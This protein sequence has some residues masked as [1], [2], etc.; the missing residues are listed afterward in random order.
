M[1]DNAKSAVHVLRSIEEPEKVL[2]AC[3]LWKCWHRR[4]K[5]NAGEKAILIDW[6]YGCSSASGC[7]GFSTD[8]EAYSSEQGYAS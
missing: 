8:G 3:M 1:C 2:V 7:V 6:D 4:N 5:I